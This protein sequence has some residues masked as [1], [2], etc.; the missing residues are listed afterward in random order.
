MFPISLDAV[1]SDGNELYGR[2]DFVTK[3]DYFPS[4]IEEEQIKSH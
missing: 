2:I 1:V 4:F 3:I